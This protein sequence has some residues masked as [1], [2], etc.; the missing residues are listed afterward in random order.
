VFCNKLSIKDNLDPV[1]SMEKSANPGEYSTNPTDWGTVPVF[2]D[3]RWNAVKMVSGAKGYRLPTEAEWEYACRAGTTTAYNTGNTITSNTGWYNDNSGD[4]GTS[5]NGKTHEVGKKSA[6]AWGLYDMHGNVWERCWD[7]FDD[8]SVGAKIDPQGEDDP[9]STYG[10]VRV[11]RGG[12]W[13]NYAQ[14]L[15]SAI[16][17]SVDPDGRYYGLGFRLVRL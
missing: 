10:A 13:D 1:Y 12:S 8:Y 5:T 14:H 17:G 4:G 3:T 6:N 15:R 11:I 9:G 2:D 7:W 16:R